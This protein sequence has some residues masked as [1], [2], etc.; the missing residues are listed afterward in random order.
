MAEG[1]W[2]SLKNGVLLCKAI[3]AIRPGTIE[4]INTK[5][6]VLMERVSGS[7]I[8]PCY[9]CVLSKFVGEHPAVS[10]RLQEAWT[11]QVRP[12]PSL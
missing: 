1:F 2:E 12:L 7:V 11:R 10:Q 8:T 9:R 3:N 4:K 5:A 6:V